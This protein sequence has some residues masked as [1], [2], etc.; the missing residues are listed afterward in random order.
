MNYVDSNLL[1][2]VGRI[3]LHHDLVHSNTSMKEWCKFQSILETT[4]LIW[5]TTRNT[6]GWK[7]GIL[8]RIA[9]PDRQNASPTKPDNHIWNSI[10]W[11]GCFMNCKQLRHR[12]MLELHLQKLSCCKSYK[13]CWNYWN[14]TV[15]RFRMLKPNIS[16]SANNI[17]NRLHKTTARQKTTSDQKPCQLYNIVITGTY[18]QLETSIISAR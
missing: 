5:Y 6:S 13:Q 2:N 17:Y 14:I 4:I 10:Q 7:G 8:W 15:T 3:F 16:Q 9:R 1:A 12:N 11:N 18:F